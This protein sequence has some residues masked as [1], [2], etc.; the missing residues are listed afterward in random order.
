MAQRMLGVPSSLIGTSI[1]QVFFQEATKEKQKT[2]KAI[3]TFKSTLKK[4]IFIS[5]P[6]FVILYFTVENL[7]IFVF[8]DEWKMAGVYTKILIPFFAIRFIVSPL[9]ISN[10]I[11]LKNRLGMLW[12]LGLLIIYLLILYISFLLEIDFEK[13]LLLFSITISIYYIYFLYIIYKHIKGKTI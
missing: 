4:L 5:L 11:N 13:L 10:Q 6:I 2:G 9:T 1:G 12:Q 8:G 7:F 3:K